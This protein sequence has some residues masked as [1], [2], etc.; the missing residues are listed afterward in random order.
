MPT[1]LHISAK[2]QAIM[3][4]AAKTALLIIDMQRD[5]LEAGGFGESLGNEVS[6]L[7]SAIEPCRK[8]LTQWRTLGLTVIHTREGHLPDLSDVPATKLSLG[9]GLKIG[10]VGSMGR[11]LIIGAAGQDIIPELYPLPTE[12][13]IDKPGKGAFYNTDLH[14][15][16]QTQCIE[17]LLVC[18][19]TSEVCVHSTIREAT[20]RG[21]RCLAVEDACASY[22]LAFHQAAMAMLSAQGGIF[23]YVTHSQYLQ[24]ALDA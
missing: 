8:L 11:I 6:L 19:V 15:Y 18:G 3:L 1:Q 2:P 9:A 13:V 7:R 17:N 23:G 10:D 20:D 21:Y 22:F 14:D 12:K 5:F 4:E 16:L 24:Q